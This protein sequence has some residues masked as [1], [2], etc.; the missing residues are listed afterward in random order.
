MPPSPLARIRK[1]CLGLPEAQEVEAWGTPTFRI[2]NKI[3]AMYAG[4]GN[5]HGAGRQALWL[6]AL[7]ETRP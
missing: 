7:A 5:H 6:K 3:F 4:A 1:L 2:R